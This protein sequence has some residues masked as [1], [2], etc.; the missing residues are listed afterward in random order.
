MTTSQMAP[1]SSVSA[2]LAFGPS[3]LPELDHENS[4]KRYA[5]KQPMAVSTINLTNSVSRP[6]RTFMH[7]TM[8]PSEPPRKGNAMATVESQ[9]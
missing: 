6:G 7:Y 1:Y 3:D 4:V 2:S 9:S 8:V 5:A